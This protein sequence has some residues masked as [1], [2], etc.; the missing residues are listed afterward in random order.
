[1]AALAAHP[2]DLAAALKPEMTGVAM[3]ET[4]PD[5]FEPLAHP[6]PPVGFGFPNQGA[7]QPLGGRGLGIR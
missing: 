5:A 2:F 4:A 6:S 1:M 7:I 3:E